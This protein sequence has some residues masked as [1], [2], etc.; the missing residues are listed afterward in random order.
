MSSD[1]L[2]AFAVS[3]KHA[4]N[5]SSVPPTQG[6][7]VDE[8]DEFGDFENVSNTASVGLE[9]EV[10]TP[11]KGSERQGPRIAEEDWAAFED[12][13]VFFDA[14]QMIT[15]QHIIPPRPVPSERSQANRDWLKAEIDL[16]NN[17]KPGIGSL[18]DDG[19]EDWPETT[20]P[21]TPKKLTSS[22]TSATGSSR[23]SNNLAKKADSRPPPSNVP[24][25]SVILPLVATLFRSLAAN[26]KMMATS[27]MPT[28]SKNILVYDALGTARAGARIIAG[29]KLRWKRD[30]FL[31][32]SMKIGP[33]SR[34]T[35][36]MKLAGLDK[37]ESRRED[38]EAA[39][40]VQIWKQ[41]VGALRSAIASMELQVTL[42]DIAE[43]IPIR[44]VK[45]S[46]GAAAAPK[47][48]FL[49][50]IKR[51]ERIAKV[52]VSVEDSFGE[53]WTEHWG[54]VECVSFWLNYKGSL[55]QR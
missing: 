8:E 42:P 33:A 18:N 49:C 39:E 30:T 12:Q 50:G 31:A 35:S 54:H 38:A 9:V 22:C 26:I 5:A 13:N 20:P 37:T 2:E 34:K 6:S 29:R 47:C 11:K 14:D 27:G 51:D 28:D 19:F 52:D 15:A 25:P 46:E 23:Q 4:S 45:A 16:N 7:G 36:G 21:T 48:C 53:W 41:H 32:Q 1:L 24:P 55:Q 3:Q 40:A 43:S 17:V 44:T 10:D